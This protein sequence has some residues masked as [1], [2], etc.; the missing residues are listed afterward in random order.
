MATTTDG[1]PAV[2]H[3]PGDEGST[4]TDTA[5][6]ARAVQ[7]ADRPPTPAV[8]PRR[9]GP[10]FT[11]FVLSQAPLALAV[12]LSFGIITFAAIHFMPA[13]ETGSGTST[14][15]ASAVGPAS[16]DGS[17]PITAFSSEPA[18]QRIP[19]ATDPTGAPRWDRSTYEARAGDVTFVV[20]NMSVSTHNFAIEGDN[21]KAQSPN[22]GSNTTNT[23]TLKGLAA[24][25]Y[26]IVSNLPGHREAGMVARLIVR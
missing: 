16:G 22:F 21:V 23:Y 18:A 17:T 2:A 4:A 8:V 7:A 25:E 10:N 13:G 9:A 1:R 6:A 24:G 14:P 26:L 19:V 11:H 5:V 20:T 15:A 12:A 3:L